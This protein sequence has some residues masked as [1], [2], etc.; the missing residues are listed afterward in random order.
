MNI[1]K[2]P[3]AQDTQI[4]LVAFPSQ[5]AAIVKMNKTRFSHVKIKK[6]III[7]VH[8]GFTRKF[9]SLQLKV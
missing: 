2:A 5:N 7:S 3:N 8:T 4:A 9:I 1:V 6:Q